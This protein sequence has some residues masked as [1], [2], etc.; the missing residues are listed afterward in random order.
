[1]DEV[2]KAFEE[3]SPREEWSMER[4]LLGRLQDVT[5]F[6]RY[7][8]GDP[9]A[10]SASLSEEAVEEIQRLRQ[11]VEALE[12]ERDVLFNCSFTDIKSFCGYPI[13][14]AVKICLR[15]KKYKEIWGDL[16]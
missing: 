11:E 2:I 14:E 7:E 6:V 8:T 12:H 3:E 13:G 5:G 15:Y 4:D 9:V 1:M 16:L 10:A